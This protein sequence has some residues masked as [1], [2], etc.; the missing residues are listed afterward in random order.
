M[1]VVDTPQVA[2]AVAASPV[3]GSVKSTCFIWMSGRFFLNHSLTPL[4]RSLVLK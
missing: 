1:S 3:A 2:P 4:V